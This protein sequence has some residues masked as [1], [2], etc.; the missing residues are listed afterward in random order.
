MESSIVKSS[1]QFS[2]VIFKAKFTRLLDRSLIFIFEN[3]K[4]APSATEIKI[5]INQ[6]S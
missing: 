2:Q 6:I 1:G 3:R 4:I 5:L